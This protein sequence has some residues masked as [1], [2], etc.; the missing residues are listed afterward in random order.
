MD[1][2]AEVSIVLLGSVMTR[3]PCVEILDTDDHIGSA[4]ETEKRPG[5][6]YI[7]AASGMLRLQVVFHMLDKES[8]RSVQRMYLESG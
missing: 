1:S 3:A 6:S 2:H 8:V 4:L 7:V 5:F